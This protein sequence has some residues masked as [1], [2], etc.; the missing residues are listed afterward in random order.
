MVTRETSYIG[1]LYFGL[2][3]DDP[4]DIAELHNG[5]RIL[6]MDQDQ[7]YIYD[8][9]AVTFHEIP[10]GGG[11]GGGSIDFSDIGQ[12]KSLNNIGYMFTAMQTGRWDYIEFTVISGTSPINLEMSED[13]AG[14]ICYPKSFDGQSPTANESNIVFDMNILTDPDS[15]GNQNSKWSVWRTRYP[16]GSTAASGATKFPSA[17]TTIENDIIICVPSNPSSS[18]THPFKFNIPYLLVYWW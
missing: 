14:W 9:A 4:A 3:T 1:Q 16:S 8:E 2:S 7:M 15:Q 6:L 5:D 18:T 13:A 10:M 17:A 11:G 12:A